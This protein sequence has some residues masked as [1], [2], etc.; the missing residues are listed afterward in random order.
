MF[1]GRQAGNSK[2][3]TFGD[4]VFHND[5]DPDTYIGFFGFLNR[6]YVHCVGGER[7]P[8][9]LP[10]CHL[11]GLLLPPYHFHGVH[12]NPLGCPLGRWD[13]FPVQP[14]RIFTEAMAIG[15]VGWPDISSTHCN[16]IDMVGECVLECI[17]FIYGP[18]RCLAL[19]CVV[20]HF[21]HNTIVH[22]FMLHPQIS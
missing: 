19:C 11:Q 15:H 2:L 17:Y 1:T 8:N 13:I 21:H 7:L 3:D 16:E 14:T 6:P 10:L 12:C 18:I 20:A 22:L 9:S 5:V 4:F